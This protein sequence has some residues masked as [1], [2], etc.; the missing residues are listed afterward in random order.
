MAKRG[1]TQ[2]EV[3]VKKHD[4]DPAFETFEAAVKALYQGKLD[5]AARSFETLAVS[6]LPELAA[7]ARQYLAVVR[8]KGGKPAA[9]R[10]ADPYLEAVV[11][12]N[13]GQLL[14]ALELC[15]GNGHDDDRFLYLAASIHALLDRPS[16]AAKVLGQAIAV[17]PV[18]RVHA[19]HDPDFAVLRQHSEHASIF[20]IG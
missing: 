7:S 20:G 18:N 1:T 14:E 13:K 11:L 2:E 6:D 5:E 16:E 9:P 4:R 15:R 17:N 12:K 19:F 3:G 10:D 8:A